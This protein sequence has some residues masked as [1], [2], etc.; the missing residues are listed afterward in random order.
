[1]PICNR[2]VSMHVASSMDRP[3]VSNSNLWHHNDKPE[4]YK[5]T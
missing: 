1:M 5:T 3:L 2:V 4:Y